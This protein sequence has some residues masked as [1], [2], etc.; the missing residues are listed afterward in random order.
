MSE[1]T[2]P[3][4]ADK[5]IID[6]KT[7]EAIVNYLAARPYIEVFQLIAAMQQLEPLTPAALPAAPAEE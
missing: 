7:A 1:T 6:I 2:Q 3:A 5:L 4:Q